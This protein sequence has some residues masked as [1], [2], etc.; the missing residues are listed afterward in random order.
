VKGYEAEWSSMGTKLFQDTVW[1]V[2]KFKISGVEYTNICSECEWDYYNIV[3][4][5][6]N[7]L[8]KSSTVMKSVI[9]TTLL[10]EDIMYTSDDKLTKI[11]K[12]TPKRQPVGQYMQTL[13]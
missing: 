13:N 12:S 9:N 11:T 1:S 7:Q 2:K 3:R 4:V 5:I 6:N 10:V 8:K